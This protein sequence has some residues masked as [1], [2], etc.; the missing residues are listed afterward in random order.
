MLEQPKQLDGRN[1]R[2]RGL[3]GK[4]R[5]TTGRSS[6]E[7]V[8]PGIVGVQVPAGKG[9]KHA[10]RKRPI[11]RDQ[12][13]RLALLDRLAQRDRNGERLLL[14]IGSLDHGECVKGGRD[15]KLGL[16]QLAPAL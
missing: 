11:G 14:G 12:R 16:R 2:Q 5:E 13:C 8:A 1:A 7:R 4:A 9:C 10:S 3:A 6:G 15:R